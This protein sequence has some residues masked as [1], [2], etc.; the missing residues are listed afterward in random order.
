[1]RRSV[2]T[3]IDSTPNF[4][5]ITYFKLNEKVSS[6]WDVTAFFGDLEFLDEL[7]AIRKKEMHT[8]Q[9]SSL[10]ADPHLPHHCGIRTASIPRIQRS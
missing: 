5:L 1:L 3:F 10:L 4:Q 7:K 6:A 2:I 8:P 9:L